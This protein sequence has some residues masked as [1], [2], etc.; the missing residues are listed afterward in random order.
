MRAVDRLHHP[1]LNNLSAD[2]SRFSAN[3]CGAKAH[4]VYD[5]DADCPLYLGFTPARVNDI[6]AAKEMPIEAGATYVFDL[7]Y[8]DFGWWTK[9][10][11]AACRIVTR[12]RSRIRRCR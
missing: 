1:S 12:L 9:L 8:Y 7:G 5:P 3:L 10:D 4:V 6:T 2:W 11:D